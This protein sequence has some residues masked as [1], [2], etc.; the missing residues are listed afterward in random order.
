[1]S[2]P[3]L[4]LLLCNPLALARPLLIEQASQQLVAAKGK[5]KQ[6]NVSFPSVSF[7]L[8]LS[9]ADSYSSKCLVTINVLKRASNT[10]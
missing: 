6:D 1:M 8:S 10:S 9:L 5:N 2:L 3:L 4:S 7:S